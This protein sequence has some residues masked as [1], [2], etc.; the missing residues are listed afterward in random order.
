MW[1]RAWAWFGVI[2]GS[3]SAGFVLLVYFFDIF[4]LRDAPAS[5]PQEAAAAALA[6]ANRH[7]PYVFA[8]P[9]SAG[10]A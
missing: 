4:D 1:L 6:A 3:V 9:R 5:A 10:G 7:H 8:S 2:G